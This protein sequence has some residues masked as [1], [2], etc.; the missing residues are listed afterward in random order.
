MIR[1]GARRAP[2]AAVSLAQSISSL[3]A[4]ILSLPCCCLQVATNELLAA[5]Y[6]TAESARAATFDEAESFLRLH[7]V[8]GGLTIE[9]RREVLHTAPTQKAE[10]FGWL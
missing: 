5:Q 2:E 10:T 6:P 7:I 8:T 9:R 4:P 3:A 1:L